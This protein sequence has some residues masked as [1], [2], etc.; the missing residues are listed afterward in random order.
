MNSRELALTMLLQIA[1]EK[2]FC[3]RVP[4]SCAATPTAATEVSP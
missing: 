3:H 1:E 2:K 4:H